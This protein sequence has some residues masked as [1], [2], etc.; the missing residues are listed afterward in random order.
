MTTISP[1]G[2]QLFGGIYV[3]ENGYTRA[4]VGGTCAD[5]LEE[6]PHYNFDYIGPAMITTFV[7]L[8][9]EW[10]DAME[11]AAT[12]FGPIAAAFFIVVVLIGKCVRAYCRAAAC[13]P[14]DALTSSH[15]LDD[16]TSVHDLGDMTS[17]YD[18][19]T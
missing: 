16:I 11:P 10:V 5:G 19:P 6:L 18:L 3:P 8:T 14:A 17:L 2:M 9:G 12:I 13:A 7:L 4:C 1:L 15:R